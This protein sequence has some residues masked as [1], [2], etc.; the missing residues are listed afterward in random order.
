LLDHL[1]NIYYTQD[2]SL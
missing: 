2:S 1:P